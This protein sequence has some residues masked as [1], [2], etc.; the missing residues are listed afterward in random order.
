MPRVCL[1]LAT[2]LLC[3][4]CQNES[5]PPIERSSSTPITP[6]Q[7]VSPTQVKTVNVAQSTWKDRVRDVL[8]EFGHRNW[9]VIADSAYPKQSTPGIETVVTR[10]DQLEVVKSVLKSIEVA[11]HVSASVM[12]DSELDLVDEGDSQ[13][14][15]AY[16]DAL[17]DLLEGTN[18]EVLPHED[19]IRKLDAESK[20][21]N[22][23]LLKTEMNIPYTSVFVR[24]ECGY[25]DAD[26]EARLRSKE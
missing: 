19:I 14:V 6:V 22:V 26:S 18:V 21:F 20:L 25:W 12:L 1:L 11:P 4:A 15:Q 16:R 2:L 24:L 5:V 10:S 7:H 9:I 17:S 8:P 13:G 3:A 23:L